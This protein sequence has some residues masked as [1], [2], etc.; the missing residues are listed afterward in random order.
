MLQCPICFAENVQQGY[1]N[2][3]AWRGDKDFVFSLCFKNQGFAIFAGTE[4]TSE[5]M[6]PKTSLYSFLY[7]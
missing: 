7:L 2:T 5:L 4:A 1:W 3:C 6:I